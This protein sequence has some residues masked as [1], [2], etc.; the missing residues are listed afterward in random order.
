MDHENN[1]QPPIQDGIESE[2]EKLADFQ[3]R[4]LEGFNRQ[5]AAMDDTP[6]KPS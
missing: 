4:T 5:L 6:E 3:R 1:P 2:R